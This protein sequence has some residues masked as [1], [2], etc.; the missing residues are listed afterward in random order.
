L[1]NGAQRVELDPK[2]IFASLFRTPVGR[3]DAANVKIEQ[4]KSEKVEMSK[5]KKCEIWKLEKREMGKL[6][7]SKVHDLRFA[8]SALSLDRSTAARQST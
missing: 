5:I 7:A 6:S 4:C 8:S 1:K 3:D 2:I